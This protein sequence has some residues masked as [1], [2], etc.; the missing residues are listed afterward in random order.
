RRGPGRAVRGVAQ[1]LW[2]APD[3]GADL[4]DRLGELPGALRPRVRDR[5]GGILGRCRVPGS[6]RPPSERR[7]ARVA[8]SP[9]WPREV[10]TGTGKGGRFDRAGPGR[11][12][13]D[14]I[15]YPA[16]PGAGGSPGG[17]G[18]WC[19]FTDRLKTWSGKGCEPGR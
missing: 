3:G 11:G 6:G 4:G 10:R 12:E 16:I 14:G 8:R 15:P 19:A 5:G 7:L 13:L 2:P 9:V 18:S 1:T 17:P